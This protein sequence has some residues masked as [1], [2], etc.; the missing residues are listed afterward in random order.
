[1][2]G[3][4]AW[5]TAIQTSR[6]RNSAERPH[7]VGTVRAAHL[8]R[9]PSQRFHPPHL[10]PS[11]A[12]STPSSSEPLPCW[13]NVGPRAGTQGCGLS[14]ISPMILGSHSSISFNFLLCKVGLITAAVA[15]GCGVNGA[16]RY[17]LGPAL[18]PAR[19]SGWHVGCYDRPSVELSL[20]VPSDFRRRS[21]SKTI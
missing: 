9:T 1:M 12:P 6:F 15:W 5:A 7:W 8:L 21:F 10:P 14:F 2:G 16:P 18:A 17:S 11:P 19:H 4:A 13:V 20:F 3:P